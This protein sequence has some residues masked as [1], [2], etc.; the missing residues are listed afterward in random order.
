MI[1]GLSP[2]SC[3]RVHASQH[4]DT[5]EEQAEKM[6]SHTFCSS[7]FSLSEVSA[8]GPNCNKKPEQLSTGSH[9]TKSLPFPSTPCQLSLPSVSPS[10][11][12]PSPKH[13]TGSFSGCLNAETTR[14]GP[15][16]SLRHL[17]SALLLSHASCPQSYDVELLAS[18]SW[19]VLP[20]VP[21]TPAL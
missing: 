9:S 15:F 13:L 19:A 8:L 4:L 11:L 20:A 1:I 2:A 18:P 7:A 10:S 12:Y 14:S 17:A 16:G 21:L 5:L 6:G 3:S